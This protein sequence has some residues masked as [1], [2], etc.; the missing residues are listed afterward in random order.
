MLR[1][2]IFLR[3]HART[4]DFAHIKLQI[5]EWGC[6]FESLMFEYTERTCLLLVVS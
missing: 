4:D 6:D 5:I 3:V 1:V 2:P